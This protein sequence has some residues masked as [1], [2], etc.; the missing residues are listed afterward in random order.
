[1]QAYSSSIMLNDK[2]GPKLLEEGNRTP[3]T[4]REEDGT[5][6]SIEDKGEPTFG[7]I[8]DVSVGK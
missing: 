2:D 3:K 4:V 1:M 5:A 6:K 8:N 7:K